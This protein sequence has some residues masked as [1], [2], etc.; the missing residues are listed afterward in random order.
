[1][2]KPIVTGVS[3]LG[4][5]HLTVLGTTLGEIAFQKGGIFKDGVPA[6]SV[7]QPEEGAAVLK[8]QAEDR[9]ASSY[10]V[11]HELPG[12]R[13][14]PLGLAGKH[15]YSNA[16]LAVY[17]CSAFMAARVPLQTNGHSNKPAPDS[18]PQLT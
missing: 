2:P 14:I 16:N 8:K 13:N 11:A 15:Q 9:K 18:A 17:L 7:E 3:S 4:L 1:V 10:T 6:F 5:D 12:L